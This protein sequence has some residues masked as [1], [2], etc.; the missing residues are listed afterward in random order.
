MFVA[1]KPVAGD[2]EYVVAPLA[3]NVVGTPEHTLVLP[4]TSKVGTG[5]TITLTCVRGLSQPDW[6]WLTK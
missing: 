6:V 4:E 2:H 3:V 5:L 1:L